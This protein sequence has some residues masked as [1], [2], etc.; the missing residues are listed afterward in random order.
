M[1]TNL[2]LGILLLA[3]AAV[4]L[5]FGYTSSQTLAEQVHE[6]FTGRFSYATIWYFEIGVG[7]A[8]G[9]VLMLSLGLIALAVKA[10]S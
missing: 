3:G 6:M 7:A 10:R 5:Y 2:L 8:V 9:G 4:L 1:N